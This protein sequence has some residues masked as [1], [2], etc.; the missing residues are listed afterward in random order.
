MKKYILVCISA[1]VCFAHTA[2][3]QM[4]ISRSAERQQLKMPFPDKLV[5]P[6]SAFIMPAHINAIKKPFVVSSDSAVK[7]VQEFVNKVQA[8]CPSKKFISTLVLNAKRANNLTADLQ[9]ETKNALKA[10]GFNIERSLA[11]SL[12]FAT[13]NFA[14]AVQGSGL[15]KNYHLPDNND[16]KGISFYRVK[17]LS[18]DT[19][20]L[21]SNIVAVKGYD[22]PLKIYPSPATDRIWIQLTAK[23]NGNAAIMLYD[24][25]GKIVQQQV[26]NCTKDELAA[27][28][29]IVSNLASGA[30]QVK[31]IM[32]DKTFLTGKFI[33]Q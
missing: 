3:A 12:H 21:Y 6:S 4:Q 20:S 33:K 32:P 31:I 9:W 17:L 18:I 25:S 24:A 15:K 13:V 29:I 19:T 28:T 22:L 26:L 27:K 11:D 16:Y 23:L 8:Q 30:Y 1:F 2:L 10:S 5:K 7:K 14:W